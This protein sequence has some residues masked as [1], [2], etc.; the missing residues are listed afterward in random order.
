M[1]VGRERVDVVVAG[2]GTAGIAAAVSAARLGARV[3]L[4]ERGGAL[5]GNAAHALVHTFCGLFLPLGG[6]AASQAI[7]AHRGFPRRFADGLRAAGGAGEPERAGKVFVLPIHPHLLEGYA[8]RVCDAELALTS[9]LGAE[10]TGAHLGIAARE[11]SVLEIARAGECVEVESR[12]VVDTTGDGAVAALG[13]ADVAMATPDELQCPSFIFRVAGAEPGCAVGFARLQLSVAAA[14]AVK[15]GMLPAGCESV[16]LRPGPAPDEVYV[17]LN[18]PRP[19]RWDPLD[20]DVVA[21]LETAARA[22]AE[23]LLAHL[24]ATR[25]AFARARVLAWPRRLGIRE[26]RRIAGRAIVTAADV[27]GGR[28]RDDEVAVSTWPIEL[29]RDHHRASFE[30]PVA[31]SSIPLGAL[32]SRSHARLGMAGRC[33]SATHEALGALRVIGAA[34]ATGEAIGVAAALAADADRVL[35]AVTPEAVRACIE[36]SAEAAP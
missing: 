18:V 9:W 11:P 13:G 20:R 29:W 35:D 25:P 4:V 15:Q 32:V 14:G 31:P 2:G 27:L 3:L 36:A 8:A 6:D 30:Y 24:H 16:L 22:S 33:A 10:V 1:S 26:T 23:Q 17:T 28:R 34:M 7:H 5:G 21:A 12:I 19:A